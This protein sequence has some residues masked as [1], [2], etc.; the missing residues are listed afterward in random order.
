[1]SKIL[2]PSAGADDWQRFL[3]KPDLQW[4]SGYSARA[5]AHCWEAA[6]GIPREVAEIMAVGFGSPELLFAVPEHKTSL[7]GGTRESQSD[8]LALVRHEAGLATYTIEGKVEEAFGDTVADWSRK[9]SDG[10]IERLTYLCATL[11]IGDC[12]PAVR[13]Q[14]IH[15]TASALIEAERFN[16][17]MAGMIVHS[18]SPARRWLDDFQSFV[19]LLGGGDVVPGQSVV[20]DPP[21]GIP[22]LLGWACGQERF[23][24]A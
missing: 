1:M 19:A 10:K 22:L 16:A 11:G 17:S 2:I 12:P 6:N 9:P 15:R 5:L 20:I 8:I 21:S 3:A 23:L 14:L 7:P 18:F 13:Y 4:K 24:T